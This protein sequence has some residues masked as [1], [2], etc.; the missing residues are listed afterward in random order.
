MTE[1]S[2]NDW[3]A[4]HKNKDLFSL[5]C[6]WLLQKAQQNASTTHIHFFAAAYHFSVREFAA[7]TALW[8]DY[9]DT[10]LSYASNELKGSHAVYRSEKLTLS[11]SNLL[12]HIKALLRKDYSANR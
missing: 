12:W 4:S 3:A 5:H 7:A 8:G 2:I 11:A 9:T 6:L 10:F 1:R